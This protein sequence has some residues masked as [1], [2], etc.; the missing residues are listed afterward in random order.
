MSR[1]F[2]LYHGPVPIRSRRVRRLIAVGRIALDAEIGAPVAAAVTRCNSEPLARQIRSCESTKIARHTRRAAHEEA[3]R[4][5]SGSRGSAIAFAAGGD[6]R[7]EHEKTS[8]HWSV[9]RG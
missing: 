4:L 1:P 9:P 5:S 7:N 8:V 3:G 6:D 2:A